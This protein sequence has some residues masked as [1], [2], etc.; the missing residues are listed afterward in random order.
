MQCVFNKK[1]IE[2]VTAFPSG[3]LKLLEVELKLI[4][5]RLAWI[6]PCVTSE[7]TWKMGSLAWKLYYLNLWNW[8][9]NLSES[10]EMLWC[11]SL[12]WKY[13]NIMSRLHYALQN[14]SEEY[15]VKWPD[16]PRNARY[17][18]HITLLSYSMRRNSYMRRCVLMEKNNGLVK[19]GFK[20]AAW[21]GSVHDE[22]SHYTLFIG[23][24]GNWMF[25]L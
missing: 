10:C 4:F 15:T 21:R 20:M 3:L 16:G 17:M 2:K 25:I 24:E 8:H 19:Y 5:W 1:V 7:Y 13:L 11:L 22:L 12:H 14:V 23:C 18:V 9:Q 6:S